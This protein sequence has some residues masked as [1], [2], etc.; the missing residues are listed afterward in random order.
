M[1][2]TLYITPTSLFLIAIIWSRI[3]SNLFF[4]SETFS[5]INFVTRNIYRSLKKHVAK[6]KAQQTSYNS[7]V[8]CSTLLTADLANILQSIVS[9]IQLDLFQLKNFFYTSF[10]TIL[11]NISSLFNY[12]M[13]APLFFV[14]ITSYMISLLH[15]SKMQRCMPLDQ[16]EYKK[17]KGKEFSYGDGFGFS[18]LKPKT[19]KDYILSMLR[20]STRAASQVVSGSGMGAAGKPPSKSSKPIAPLEAVAPAQSPAM[21]SPTT[22]SS[23]HATAAA[24][25]CGPVP[26]VSIGKTLAVSS[27]KGLGWTVGSL[28]GAAAMAKSG[29]L[30]PL[31]DAVMSSAVSSAAENPEFKESIQNVGQNLLDVN[32]GTLI[33]DVKNA[34]Q[35][36][37]N[38]NVDAVSK[39]IID[40]AK[41]RFKCVIL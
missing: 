29:V 32:K 11:E 7:I 27:A 2:L 20:K 6:N 33:K 37:I 8:Y 38:E 35:D 25:S 3:N 24:S 23:V 40:E 28:T 9:K 34:G 41:S 15:I 16:E 36:L 31:L 26:G 19:W 17:S 13:L 14:A 18:V 5:T 12:S 22:P 21:T 1:L 39:K 10:I 4:L 30:E